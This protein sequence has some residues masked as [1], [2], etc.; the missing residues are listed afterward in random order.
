MISTDKLSDALR[1]LQDLGLPPKQKNDRSAYT[2][3]A[4]VNIGPSDSWASVQSPLM[5]VAPIMDWIS[6][7]YS[8]HYKVGS[9]ESFRRQT[10]HQFVSGGICLYNPDKPSRPVNSPKACYQIAPEVRQLLGSFGTNEWAGALEKWK[11]QRETLAKQYAM[12]RQKVLIPVQFPNGNEVQLSPGDHS[13][14]IRNIVEEFAPRFVGGAE[15]VYLGDTGA[16]DDFLDE[17]KLRSLG[18]TVDRKGKLPD[19]VMYLKS[20]NWLLLIESVTSHGPVDGKRYEELKHLFKESTADLVFVSAFPDKKTLNKFISEISWETEAWI[21]D[22]PTHL[23]HF[24]G[25]KFLGPYS[26]N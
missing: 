17:E 4:L 20:K 7:T 1:V 22:S 6:K 15:V 5:G 2:L 16:K 14:L 23:I 19:V 18:V 10:L 9:R 24:N 12:E 13:N 11:S 3:L 26:Q 25:D 21:A 8:K